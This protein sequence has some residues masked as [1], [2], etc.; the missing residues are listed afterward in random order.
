[1]RI[2]LLIYV[3]VVLWTM[4]C[5]KGVEN[6]QAQ[7]DLEVAFPR[8]QFDRPVDLQHAGDGT[9]R[10][11][12]LEQHRGIIRVF[13][14]DPATTTS[15]VFLDISVGTS[16][17]EGLLGLAF[18]PDFADNG[19]FY[20][21]YSAT[22]PRRS[23]VARYQVDPNDPNRANP[24]SEQ[25]VLEVAQ[26][27]GNHNGGQIAFGPDGYLYIALGDGGS[28]GDPQGNGQNPRTLLG[29][30]LRID[31]DRSAG[32]LNYGIPADNPF[33][34]NTMGY[35]EEI[36][37]YGL[38]NPW[39]F[40]FDPETGMMWSG[41]VGQNAY[42][43][44]DIIQSGGNY[45]WNTMEGLHCFSPS[46][47]CDQSGLILPVWEYPHSQGRSITGGYVYR[48]PTVPELT[49][50]YIYGDFTSGRIWALAYDGDQ[51]VENVE[52]LDTGF[53][54][55]SFGTD[56][57]NELYICAFDGRIYRFVPTV[58]TSVGEAEVP[59]RSLR[60][61]P[62]H[63]NPFRDA[64]TITYTLDHSAAVDLAV[65]DARGR[66]VH[67]L[68]AGEQQAGEHRVRWNGHADDGLRLAAGIYFARLLVAG[69]VEASRQMVLV[70]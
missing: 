12:V 2:Q 17:E 68:A 11:F 59:E 46:S 39:R 70:R 50:R 55:A 49:G 54:I 30:I 48:G 14:N 53:G 7:F 27:Y 23:V 64:T 61:S 9:D 22:G 4:G 10:L 42:E 1:M 65:Y 43:E 33:A 63:P 15:T 60:L 8:L 36:Y 41:D 16:N 24:D 13:T 29:S 20:I 51:A 57:N 52:L 62:A 37:A 67:T 40:S 3:F 26:P 35:R 28:A 69:V 5:S 31:V 21:Y 58:S 19:Y 18:H 6:V 47:G 25:V 38:R 56:P 45:G 34:G 66:R 44:V 32:G